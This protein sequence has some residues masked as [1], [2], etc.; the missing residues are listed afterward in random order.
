MDREFSIHLILYELLCLLLE[1]GLL[2]DEVPLGVLVLVLALALD[3]D[4]GH[5]VTEPFAV[6][7][8]AGL[9]G[10]DVGVEPILDA[11]HVVDLSAGSPAL[12]ELW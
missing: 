11:G 1:V 7:G 5:D 4:L 3:D 2:A 9:L 10:L 6:T 8:L 12:L